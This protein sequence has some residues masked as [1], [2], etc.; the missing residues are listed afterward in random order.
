MLASALTHHGL[1]RGDAVAM[2]MP[3]GPE[4]IETFL[5]I[6]RAAAC[7]QLNPAFRADEFTFYLADLSARALV[8]AAIGIAALAALP[9]IFHAGKLLDQ[10]GR[11]AGA[12]IIFGIETAGALGSYSLHGFWPLTAA[13]VLGIFGSSAVL[14]VLNTYTAELFPTELRGGAF[15]W[16]N[17]LLGRSGYVL[18]PLLVGYLASMTDWGF[19][20]RLTA[21]GPVLALAMLLSFAPE[22]KARELEETSR[23]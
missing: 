7:A 1:T 2:A 20:V 14:L 3:E 12:V 21:I 5:A 11:R 9:L 23:P 6:T 17:N 16:S 15:A 10:V 8:G 13:L 22:T 4:A 19:A 18:S